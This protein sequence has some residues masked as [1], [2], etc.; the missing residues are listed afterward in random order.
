MEATDAQMQEFQA[1][2]VK[3]IMYIYTRIKTESGET[4]RSLDVLK[5]NVDS[6]FENYPNVDGIFFDN[7]TENP[8]GLSLYSQLCQYTRAKKA[9]ITIV[10]N[11]GYPLSSDW[12]ANYPNS[13]PDIFFYWESPGLASESTLASISNS[14]ADISRKAT[15]PHS[16]SSASVTD[17]QYYHQLEYMDWLYV[18]DR[19]N[20]GWAYISTW[21]DRQMALMSE[22]NRIES[23]QSVS[24]KTDEFSMLPPTASPPTDSQALRINTPA[25]VIGLELQEPTDDAAGAV[26]VN[27]PNGVK[28]IK[29]T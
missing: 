20:P 11:P 1:A 24:I 10:G 3:C 29:L 22:L 18:Q 2:G 23:E 25:G 15:I 8:G 13:S 26:R 27:T 21:L 28:S 5:S 12:V 6:V 7:W 19:V 17:E 9:G 16:T 14:P 4:T